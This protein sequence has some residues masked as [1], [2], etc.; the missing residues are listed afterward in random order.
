MGAPL[1]AV[2]KAIA[3]GVQVPTSLAAQP[4]LAAASLAV[5]G[6]ADVMMP[7]GMGGARPL[8]LYC[9]SVADSSDRKSTCDEEALYGK[10]L[11]EVTLRLEHISIDIWRSHHAAWKAEKNKISSKKS[12]Y[13]DR[14]AQ[15]AAHYEFEPK[16]PLEPWLT[17][18]NLTIEGLE[19]YWNEFHASLGL[20]TT[21]GA[22][23]TSGHSM[24]PDTRMAAAGTLSKLWDA[25]PEPR[26]RAGQDGEE[27][28]AVSNPGRRLTMHLLVQ[29]GVANSFICDPDL[30]GQGLISRLLICSSGSIAGARLFKDPDPANVRE[31]RSFSARL[32]EILRAPLPLAK[33]KR[34]ELEPRT[35]TISASAKEVWKDF[36]N[37]VEIECGPKGRFAGIKDFAG[38]AG[39]NAARIAGVITLLD[40]LNATETASL[41]CR[42]RLLSWTGTSRRPFAS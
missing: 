35:L 24:T 10:T 19:K 15:M 2:T 17:T 7:H 9:I 36:Y 31:I 27:R 4:V 5:C 13:S 22:I 25:R 34:N 23:F 3:R 1:A 33:D 42:G 32:C 39:E 18:G 11:H 29:P 21:E 6:H 28:R 16:K 20:F 40:S 41:Q 30:R 8:S 26:I 14:L 38:K 37:R 12:G